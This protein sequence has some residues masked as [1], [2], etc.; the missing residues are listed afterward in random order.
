MPSRTLRNRPR[1]SRLSPDARRA[2]L[3]EAGIHV[4]A[5]R[6][7]GA[8]RPT[9]VAEEAGVSEATF[10]VYFPNREA[11]VDAVL[12]E[13]ARYYLALT[14]ASFET[15]LPL[16]DQF[17]AILDAAAASI[18][19]HPDH[20]RVWFNWASAMSG[21]VWPRFLKAQERMSQIMV[22]AVRRVPP[23]ERAG[24]NLHPSDLAHLAMGAA[25]MMVRMKFAGRPPREIRRFIRSTLGMLFPER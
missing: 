11:L 13:V 7:I 10:Y 24:L 15:D 25:E 6:G 8:A 19:T 9:E 21:K 3:V 16:A 20:A 23:K 4:V 12:D 22:S 5:R 2:S 1:A 14:E 18:D 17:A